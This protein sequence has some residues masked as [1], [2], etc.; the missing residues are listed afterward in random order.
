[1]NGR[2]SYTKGFTRD[3]VVDSDSLSLEFL[4][5]CLSSEMSWGRNQKVVFWVFDKRSGEEVQLVS[6]HQIVDVLDMYKP[7]KRFMLLAS[8]FDNDMCEQHEQ[9]EQLEPI[10]AAP[11]EAPPSEGHV[12]SASKAPDYTK[13]G[14]LEAAEYEPELPDVFDKGVCW[15]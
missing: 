6:D 12:S 11:S 1:M 4:T 9:P 5:T 8:V 3:W 14:G 10:C 13:F 2:K 7:E 15:C